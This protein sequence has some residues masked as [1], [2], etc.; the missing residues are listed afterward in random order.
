MEYKAAGGET[1]LICHRIATIYGQK[2]LDI[3]EEKL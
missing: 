2:C 1:G 3:S